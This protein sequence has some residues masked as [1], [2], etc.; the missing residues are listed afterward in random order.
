MIKI[1][2]LKYLF[3]LIFLANSVAALETEISFES[4]YDHAS[5]KL[6]VDGVSTSYSLGSGGD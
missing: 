4:I 6:T 1:F 5:E 2:N 3:T